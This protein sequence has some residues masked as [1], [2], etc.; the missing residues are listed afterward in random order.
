MGCC[1]QPLGIPTPGDSKG[2]PY[3]A[4][5]PKYESP[6]ARKAKAARD[7]KR[8][9]RFLGGRVKFSLGQ[10][11]CLWLTLIGL[12]LMWKVWGEWCRRKGY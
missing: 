6:A 1:G 5:P 4:T 8:K 10:V 7:E 9:M 2:S 12:G 11:L 3:Q